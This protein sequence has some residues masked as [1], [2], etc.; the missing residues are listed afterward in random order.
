MIFDLT[1]NMMR[2]WPNEYYTDLTDALG[3]F[4]LIGQ[5]TG[6][7]LKRLIPIDFEQPDVKNAIYAVVRCHGIWVQLLNPKASLPGILLACE[8]S[9][10]QNLV[11]GLFRHGR[12]LGLKPSGL[13]SFEEWLHNY[14]LD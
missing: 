6:D 7:L 11:D 1:G 3:L 5:Q 9:H 4:A 13:G 8:R 10:C 14:A 12:H 2:I